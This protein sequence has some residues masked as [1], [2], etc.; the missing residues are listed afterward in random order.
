MPASVTS[1]EVDPAAELA[2]KVLVV[3]HDPAVR[4]AYHRDLAGDCRVIATASGH[5]AVALV[6]RELAA[7]GQI[8]AAFVELQRGGLETLR[9]LLALDSEL[10]C[11]V[12][13]AD[14]EQS[15]D[16]IRAL[17]SADRC[18]E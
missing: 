15:P 7:G 10:M 16:A 1:M 17:F 11:V 13:G 5:D 6:R 2:P 9:R 12:V 14:P 3:D 18:D 8:Q 4:E